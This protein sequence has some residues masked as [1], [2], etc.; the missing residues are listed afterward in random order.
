MVN[1]LLKPCSELYG[2]IV[3]TLSIGRGGTLRSRGL[4]HQNFVNVLT[5][6][7]AVNCVSSGHLREILNFLG[8]ARCC[9]LGEHLFALRLGHWI[10]ASARLSAHI[11]VKRWK[12][13]RASNVTIRHDF[14]RLLWL[15]DGYLIAIAHRWLS[16]QTIK[17]AAYRSW[18]YNIERGRTLSLSLLLFPLD[19][20]PL[21]C[22]L[23]WLVNGVGHID[24]LEGRCFIALP[25]SI[26]RVH[27]WSWW[28]RFAL[29]A[30]GVGAARRQDFGSSIQLSHLRECVR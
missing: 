30:L 23:R 26:D 18:F 12:L 22:T 11:V 6:S 2:F 19:A 1:Q 15:M 4:A 13:L 29:I 5:F 20:E 10:V 9:C 21:H 3:L 25:S 7:K 8:K 24:S 17:K 14:H 16:R 28:H 27:Y